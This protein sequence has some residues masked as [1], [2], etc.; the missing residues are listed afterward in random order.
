[1]KHCSHEILQHYADVPHPELLLPEIHQ[2]ISTCAVCA[3]EVE[4]Y[5]R[6]GVVLKEKYVEPSANFTSQL[7]NSLVAQKPLVQPTPERFRL[8]IPAFVLSAISLVLF[9]WNQSLPTTVHKATIPKTIEDIAP[10]VING[11]TIYTASGITRNIALVVI[12]LV[13]LFTFERAFLQRNKFV[14]K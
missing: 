5:K 1:M 9:F 3:A 6:T 10:S 13:I 2:H 4:I 11:L 12:A 8:L 14:G 7:M